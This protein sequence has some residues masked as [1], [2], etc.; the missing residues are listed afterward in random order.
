MVFKRIFIARSLVIAVLLSGQQCS[1]AQDYNFQQLSIQQGLPQSQAYAILFDSKNSAWIGTQG[2]G[3]C[4]YD[5]SEVRTIT[6]SDSLISNRVY[7]LEEI[8]KEVWVGQKG[9]VTILDLEGNFRRNFVFQPKS[10]IV[11][12]IVSYEGQVLLATNQG[13]WEFVAGEFQQ[14]NDNPN[15]TTTNCESFFIDLDDGLWCC[16][17]SGMF[18]FEDPLKKISKDRKI[19][20]GKRVTCAVNYENY[21]VVGTYDG[22]LNILHP[23]DGRIELP[24]LE[25]LQDRIILSLFVSNNNELWIGTMNFGVYVYNQDNGSIK[26]FQS[27]NGLTNNHVKVI[28]AD[29]WENVWLGTSGGGI[30]IFQNSPFT[31][32]STA[33]GLNSNYIFS[34]L[35]DRE[36]NLWVSTEGMGVVRINDTSKVL[37]DEEF[38]F[39]SSKVKAIFQDNQGDI[40]FGTE[41]EGLGV[42]HQLDDK[43][44]VYNIKGTNG[45][46]ANW[47]KC[48]AQEP[49]RGGTIYLGTN[50]G[51]IY[52]VSKGNNFPQSMRFSKHRLNGQKLPDKVVDLEFID[53]K[54][55][56]A[57]GTNRN[58]FGFIDDGVVRNYS[59]DATFRTVVG[60]DNHYWLGTSESGILS[61][62]IEGDS[63]VRKEW[64]TSSHEYLGSNNIYQLVLDDRELWA[65]TEKGLYRLYLDSAYQIVNGEHYG[66]E[67]GFD[68]MEA[69]INS[70]F[71][72]AKGNIWFGTVDGLYKYQG[73]EVN[74]AQ[75]KP[76]ILWMEDFQISYESI[77]DSDYSGYY[78][79]GRM[80]KDLLL[81]YDQNNISF[82]FKAIHFTYSKDIRYS[83][84]LSGFD[85]DWRPPSKSSEATYS[86]LPPG[87]YTFQ[88][89]A[90]I[91]D[92]WEEIEPISI[93]FEIDKPYWDKFW[94]KASYY[95][96][97]VFVV[98]LIVLFVLLR[99]RR[100]NRAFREKLEMEK[101][102]IELEQQALR[103]Q[104]NPH[105][106]FNV[107]NSIHNL[108]ILKDPDKARYALAKFSKLMRRVLEN[109][110]SK[111]ISIDDEMETLENYVQLE[112]LTTNID[113]ELEFDMDDDLDTAEELLPPL[114]IQPFIENAIIHGLRDLDRPGKVKVGFKL[115][116]EH[117][118][119]C[120]IE[121]NGRGRK[122]ASEINAQKANYH[123]STALTV[124]QERLSNLNQD[125]SFIP[126]EIID[127]KNKLG[128][129]EGT[130]IIFRLQV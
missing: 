93:Q 7:A 13:V 85:P 61:F 52:K 95:G 8:E 56:Y 35:N 68:G 37:F 28:A 55:W 100:K 11:Q 26:N 128:D 59:E 47:V 9:G 66:A 32:Y 119:E 118:L 10:I 53:G 23:T 39:H 88:V 42:F 113:L 63:M 41:G 105:F 14:V 24:V 108:I 120:S 27:S 21:K 36:N 80:V 34:V 81:P 97:G 106:I 60:R 69:N 123:K 44:T 117:L 1:Y 2:G 90:S 122:K 6:K 30:S 73:G 115:L 112:K 107:L 98:L 49:F 65:G 130:Q 20:T 4:A 3:L 72:D 76:P 94:F 84:K 22:G 104:M 62:R 67:E 64:I 78:E 103:L 114:M 58:D 51:G 116:H 70:N 82:L 101:N 16:T 45:L 79:E 40:W 31:K 48:F 57:T 19:L 127:K 124:T 102:M 99:I 121:D 109:S 126:F 74:Y 46:S 129:S 15:L 33:Q 111:F 29:Y 83:W 43:D 87:N 86:N 125:D 18:H 77:E 91:D 38:G 12:D 110:R 50:D 25:E 92:Y 5:G 54:M 89:K 75:R 17:Q 71:L 96:L